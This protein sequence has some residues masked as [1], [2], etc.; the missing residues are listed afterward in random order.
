MTVD[1]SDHY[2]SFWW[3]W[4]SGS[5]VLMTRTM[6]V[7]DSRPCWSSESFLMTVLMRQLCPNDKDHGNGWQPTMVI[8]RKLS[9]GDD[10]ENGWQKDTQWS[11]ESFL[12]A[13]TMRMADSRPQWSSESFLK[14]GSMSVADSQPQWSSGIF[15]SSRGRWLWL[16]FEQTV[17]IRQKIFKSRTMALANSWTHRADSRSQW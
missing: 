5:F 13:G 2:Q 15:F 11:S 4:S 3:Q 14:P 7:T 17:I 10:N 6:A 12:K 1:H 9:Q 8:T 16:T